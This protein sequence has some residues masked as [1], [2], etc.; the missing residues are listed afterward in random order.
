MSRL[1]ASVHIIASDGPEGRAGAT[2]SSVCSVSDTPPTLLA[3]LNRQSY[4]NTLIK[5]NKVFTI[6]TLVHNHTEISDAFAGRGDLP[7]EERF[8]LGEWMD[9]A[10]GAPALSNARV[11]FDCQLM[12]VSEVGTHS[13]MFGKVVAVHYGFKNRALIYMDRDYHAI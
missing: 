12:Q 6:N 2:V 4:V 3:C 1:G 13:V 10:T 9:L 5:K 8:A 11:S 7:M